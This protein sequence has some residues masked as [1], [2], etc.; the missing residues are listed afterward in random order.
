MQASWYSLQNRKHTQFVEE[1]AE[2]LKK[3]RQKEGPGENVGKCGTSRVS[4]EMWATTSI[5]VCTV[6]RRQNANKGAQ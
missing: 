2:Q 3:K 4:R 5:H 1:R 6:K